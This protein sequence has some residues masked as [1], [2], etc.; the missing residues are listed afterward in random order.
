MRLFTKLVD[1][2]NST[3]VKIVFVFFVLVVCTTGT[4]A[5][6]GK[7]YNVRTFGATGDGKTDDSAAIQAAVKAAVGSTLIIPP[8]IF[9]IN[10]PITIP[11]NSHIINQGT[12]MSN[13]PP[14]RMPQQFFDIV[15][16]NVIIDGLKFSLLKETSVPRTGAGCCIT[17]VADVRDI[18]IKNC[19]IRYFWSCI[20]AEKYIENIQIYNNKFVGV[21]YDVMLAGVNVHGKNILIKNNEFLIHRKWSKPIVNA[22]AIHVGG[23]LAING[24]AKP[25]DLVYETMFFEN[26]I[27]QKNYIYKTDGRPIRCYNCKSIEV[28]DNTIQGEVGDKVEVG[29]SDDALDLELC[30]NFS[31]CR[32]IIDAGGE[33]G[34][35]ILS[36]QNGIVN[37]NTLTRIDDAG[38][39]VGATDWYISFPN[40][41]LN[42]KYL[43]TQHIICK[44]NKI[45]AAIPVLIFLGNNIQFLDNNFKLWNLY[46]ARKKALGTFVVLRARPEEKSLIAKHNELAISN[47]VFSG[48]KVDMG[49]EYT[50]SANPAT[51]IITTVGNNDFETGEPVEIFTGGNSHTV[52]LP[53]PLNY[54]TVYWTIKISN[55]QLKLASTWREAQA[56]RA[57]DLKTDGGGVNQILYLRRSYSLRVL[58][59]DNFLKSAKLDTIQLQEELANQRVVRFSQAGRVGQ[60]Q[61]LG[62][63][64]N[65]QIDYILDPSVDYGSPRSQL[66]KFRKLPPFYQ[67]NGNKYGLSVSHND[68]SATTFI[69]GNRI[70]KDPNIPRDGYLRI[71]WW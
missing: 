60:P 18:V 43:S 48:N 69:K 63:R 8:G 62:P 29:I 27:I 49:K 26:V 17:F 42:K 2:V 24:E 46:S 30:R 44:G 61:Y 66:P 6:A 47:I 25:S 32:N 5:L 45:E 58:R 56:G 70:S 7:D 11:G 68:Y 51:D 33:N 59:D 9:L 16:N 55:N 10:S 21:Y 65:I 57:I 67:E 28:N 12:I 54:Y 31:V 1:R 53:D 39:G 22:G 34:I 20:K 3:V 41:S 36:C 15:G 23:G 13:L 37:D 14:D 71:K 64:R 38:I 4:G 19:D 52:D 35:D 40:I 50:F